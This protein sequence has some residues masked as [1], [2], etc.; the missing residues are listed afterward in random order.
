[1]SFLQP[2][3]LA[4]L[5]LI[6][7]PVIIHLINQ[8]RYQST[9]WAAMMFLLAANRMSRGYARLR[10][11]LILL[12]RV[13]VIMA[14]VL[15]VSRPLSSGWLGL[16]GGSRP[17]TTLILLD[18]SPSMQQ[19]N[20]RTD[21]AKLPWAIDQLVQ[22]LRTLGSTR[23]AVIDS[24]HGEAQDL[25][26]IEA[27]P[28]LAAVNAASNSADLPTMLEAV[29]DYVRDNRPG[30]TDVWIAS[31]LQLGDWNADSARWQA[32]RDEF[33]GFPQGL[34]FHLLALTEPAPENVA[35][36][37]MEARRVETASAAELWLSLRLTRNGESQ[38]RVTLPVV[39]QIEAARTVVPVE[40]VGSQADLKDHR[41]TLQREQ[42]RG[43]GAVSIPADANAADN[44]YYFVFDEPP[45]RNSVIVADQAPVADLLTVAATIS[46]D[47]RGEST[48][49]V[50]SP[51]Q[52]PS[53]AWEEVALLLWQG[54]LPEGEAATH[55]KAFLNRG[56]QAIF[57]ASPAAGQSEFLGVRWGDWISDAGEQRIVTWRG[58]HDLLIN[59]A[60][61]A[62]LPVGQIEL[63]QR[64]ELF[65]DLTP[66]AT[67][68][69][70]DP[71]LGRAMHGSGSAYFCGTTPAAADSSLASDGVV[72]YVMVQR[73]LAAGTA[74]LG[75]THQ[76]DAA[77]V[78]DRAADRSNPA[79]RSADHS[80][81]GVAHS[82]DQTQA[83][84]HPHTP[85]FFDSW[86]RLAG[87]ATALS[88]EY[89]YQA[90][91]YSDA[92]RLLAINRPLHEDNPAIL[93][94]ERLA[95]LFG[96]LDFTR[97]DAE[98]G[99][100]G[101]LVQEVWRLFVLAMITAMMFEAGLSMP[102]QPRGGAAR[103]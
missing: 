27:L 46:P 73:A 61:G 96:E 54:P 74:A 5:P 6:A 76:L 9:P 101:A 41:I 92:G 33:H 44:E 22:T 43:W 13:A 7:L 19:R 98:V 69:S 26:S 4:A 36:R 80:E 47:G 89:P 94:D 2:W 88:S 83:D 100:G 72:F 15:A 63:R 62:A 84:F 12:L 25:A 86:Q 34:R 14:L 31:D 79:D 23:W 35:I 29:R 32:L 18:R 77:S 42:R 90:G 3:I 66:L 71:L 99:R 55:V 97:V 8:R 95:E 102:R 85:R 75:N 17:D 38:P 65:G 87:P 20:V 21:F 56:G 24:A 40:L 10:Q 53:V 82:A 50:I 91:I 60:S 67:L 70:G 11:W 52:I 58:D 51:S 103:P 78:V 57:F 45:P 68:A 16:A 1:M 81:P 37:V 48:A 49:E 39:I 93:Q 28:D 30:R 64:M 59:T